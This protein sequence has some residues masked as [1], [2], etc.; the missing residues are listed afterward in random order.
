MEDKSIRKCSSCG[1]VLEPDE[2][3][4]TKCGALFEENTESSEGEGPIGEELLSLAND[5][6]CVNRK[7]PQW[8]ELTSRPEAQVPGQKVTIKYEAVAQLVPGKYQVLFWEKMMETLVGID[9]GSSQAS[10]IQNIDANQEI[11]GHLMFGGPYG[12]RY[13]RLYRVVK[14]IANEWGWQFELSMSKPVMD[15]TPPRETALPSQEE[16]AY[17]DTSRKS[18]WI[19]TILAGAVILVVAAALV[20]ILSK[21]VKETPVAEKPK[22]AAVPHAALEAQKALGAA[23]KPSVPAISAAVDYNAQGMRKAKAGNM[24]EAAGLFEKAVQASPDNFNAWNNLGLA[25]RKIGRNEK[26]VKAYQRAIAINPDFALVYKNL[27][28]VFEQMG[29][30]KEAAEAYLKYAELNRSAADARTARK[31]AAM[32]MGAAQGKE[33]RP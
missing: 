3:I 14:S 22:T 27:G 18:R 15:F 20:G 23:Q 33:T 2:D 9:A 13:D 32:L 10:S 16:A 11:H 28:I 24:K 7:S 5:F 8:F 17:P 30:K 4:C 1:K 19:P 25:L 26:A 12:F 29:R 21:G 6:L 31:K